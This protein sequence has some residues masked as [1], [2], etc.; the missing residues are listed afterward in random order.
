MGSIKGRGVLGAGD[1][2]PV[3]CKK[4]RTTC[5]LLRLWPTSVQNPCDDLDV[6]DSGLI[7]IEKKWGFVIVNEILALDISATNLINV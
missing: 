2:R 4:P 7:R 3:K 1:S 6:E 5:H